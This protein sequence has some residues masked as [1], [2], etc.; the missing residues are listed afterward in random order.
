MVPHTTR[1]YHQVGKSKGCT[2]VSAAAAV[3]TNVKLLGWT[4]APDTAAQLR[5]LV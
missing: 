3:E 1:N 4:A 2:A 5:P